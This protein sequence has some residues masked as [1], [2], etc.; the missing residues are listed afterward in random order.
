MKI[1]IVGMIVGIFILIV[2]SAFIICAMVISE[3]M[4][5][6]EETKKK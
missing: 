1:S 3:E 5:N 6:Y 4:S 2:L